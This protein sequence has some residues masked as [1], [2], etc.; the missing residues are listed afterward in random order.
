MSADQVYSKILE[1]GVDP[2]D[3]SIMVS[4]WIVATVLG[5]PRTFDYRTA[6][7]AVKTDCRV[8]FTRSFA[9]TDWADGVSVVQA[10]E[11]ISEQGF[12]VRFHNIEHDLDALGAGLAKVSLCMADMR[13]DL[14]ALL[15]EI[16]AALNRLEAMRVTSEDEGKV[17]IKKLPDIAVQKPPV[18]LGTT[19]YFGQDVHVW[20]TVAGVITLPVVN[21]VA[22]GG[23]GNIRVQRARQLGQ[24]VAQ[25]RRLQEAI[26]RKQSKADLVIQF[27]NVR[28]EDGSTF[29]DLID[30]LP[31]N[32]TWEN[33]TAF[34]NLVGSFE[35]GALRTTPSGTESIASSLGTANFAAA[36]LDRLN[37]VP[38]GALEALEAAGIDTVQKLA[39][40]A[41][42]RV[43]AI[44]ATAAPGVTEADAAGWNAAASMLINMAGPVARR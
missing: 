41:P 3:A 18:Y 28:A 44:A 27:G 34:V 36:P 5:K 43:A 26:T 12:N 9:H 25:D 31:A 13:A 15:D 10:E 21:P 8:S 33:V 14:R 1:L 17:S 38:A 4:D 20:E 16:K 37:M 6:F 32:A 29:G 2:S 40:A 24:L 22:L 35:A 19:E 39:E 11:T 23:V 42:D 30:I 7:P